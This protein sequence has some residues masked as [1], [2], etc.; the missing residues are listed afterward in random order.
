MAKR[1]FVG[2]VKQKK[3]AQLFGFNAHRLSDRLSGKNVLDSIEETHRLASS[4]L[5]DLHDCKRLL[6]WDTEH[7]SR[8]AKEGHYQPTIEFWHEL[9]RLLIASCL[10]EAAALMKIIEGMAWALNSRNEI[11]FALCMRSYI[12]HA[13]VINDLKTAIFRP[14]DRISKE[15]WPNYSIAQFNSNDMEVRDKLIRF[16][17]GRIAQLDENTSPSRSQAG[18]PE[19]EKGA[20]IET[21]ISHKF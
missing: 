6:F 13:S 15:V 12:E 14:L 1:K 9:N 11:I 19:G 7:L 10:G 5:A 4:I 3:A 17:R 16:V 18:Y 21:H 20:H 8:I 2:A